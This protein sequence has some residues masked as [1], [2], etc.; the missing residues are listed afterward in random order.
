MKRKYVN[1][2]TLTREV[3]MKSFLASSFDVGEDHPITGPV[4]APPRRYTIWGDGTA[5]D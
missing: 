4:G 1:P 5:S 3:E 2:Q